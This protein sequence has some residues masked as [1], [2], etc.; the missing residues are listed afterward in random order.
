MFEQPLQRAIFLDKDGTIVED[1]PYNVDIS[2]IRL[3]PGAIEA[4]TRL[5]AAGYRLVVIT[6]QSGVALGH[7]DVGALHDVE[8]F[9]RT[10]F[11]NAGLTLSGFYYCPHHKDGT[12]AEFAI[13]CECRKPLP[14]LIQRAGAELGI[15]LVDS[16]MVGDILNDV[17]AGNRAGCR[18]V[19]VD[20]GGETE[21]H[22]SAT[23]C[24]NY[25]VSTLGEAAE[26]ILS[27]AKLPIKD[28]T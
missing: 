23:R 19:L 20:T 28:L 8:E 18:T 11:R 9:L 7:F 6:N 26:V 22:I 2:R 15:N 4:L 16:W 17:E 24:P 21:W 14:G 3:F 13:H 5:H 27:D 10:M 12:V 1:V 25:L